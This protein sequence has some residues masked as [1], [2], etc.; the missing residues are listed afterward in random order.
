MYGRNFMIERL[1]HVTVLVR[2]EDEALDFYTRKLGFKVVE[3][4]R[5]PG[6]DRWLTVAPPGDNVQI[7]LQ[8]PGPATYGDNTGEMLERVGQGTTWVFKVDDCRGT[9]IELA[10]KGVR[11][12]SPPQ[13]LGFAVEA[14]FTDL[15]GN[16]F[17]LME[18][19]RK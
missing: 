14:V 9:C 19:S 12:L 5:M 8:K 17:T 4:A 2:N 15:Y 6:G 11:I 18:P 13:D 10:K 3:D 7:V 1:T 16:A